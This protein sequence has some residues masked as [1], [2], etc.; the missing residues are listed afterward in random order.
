MKFLQG[1]QKADNWIR[2]HGRL[3]GYNATAFGY[4]SETYAENSLAALGGKVG[5]NESNYGVNSAAIGKDATVIPNN[6]YAMGNKA[7]VLGTASQGSVAL[8]GLAAN[9]TTI[10]NAVNAFAAVGGTVNG[11]N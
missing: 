9:P 2:D 5:Q 1:T 3:A 7:Q 8:G 6:A 10:T 11:A 4:G